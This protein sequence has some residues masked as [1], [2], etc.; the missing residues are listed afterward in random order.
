MFTWYINSIE[1]QSESSNNKFISSTLNDG[2][3]VS[4]VGKY[5]ATSCSAEAIMPAI[6][7]NPLPIATL[8]ASPSE[9]I[10]SGTRI[11]S[12]NVCYTK[13]LR[14]RYF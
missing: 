12:Y 5:N 13:L 10:I 4:V 11:T 7:V 6:S 8:T 3:V 9:T 1:V 2:E 14:I